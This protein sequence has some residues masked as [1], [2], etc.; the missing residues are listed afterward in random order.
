L[1]TKVYFLLLQKISIMT[2]GT[3]LHNLRRER[4]ISLDKMAFEL[5]ITKAAIGKWE[6]DKSKPSIDNLSKLCD[7]YE[8][9]VY[10]LLEDVSNV[11]FANAK[12]K[13]SS[14]AA[15]AQNFTVNYSNSP[16][17]LDNQKQITAL[18]QKQNELMLKLLE[19][20]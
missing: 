2:L 15:Y 1:D 14:Y 4:E 5:D 20:K 19:G 12:F 11:N 13:G 18:I 10:K 17:L 6:A 16:E 7:Y 3:K 9:D 8:V